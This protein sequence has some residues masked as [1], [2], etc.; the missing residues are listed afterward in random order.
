MVIRILSGCPC[1]KVGVRFFTPSG[2][3]KASTK[4]AHCNQD[5]LCLL[6][7]TMSRPSE[8]VYVI[9]NRVLSPKGEELAITFNGEKKAT[10]LTPKA[11]SNVQKWR[12]KNYDAKTMSVTPINAGNLQAAWGNGFVT[13]LPA[14]NF[15]WTIKSSDTG[16]TIRDGGETV[17]WGTAHAAANQDVT[18]GAGTGNEK[19]RWIFQKSG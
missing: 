11:G 5:T 12:L 8:G 9:V 14:G 3:Y 10:T 2:S 18:I 6:P 15:V 4:L 19:Q 1:Q 16:Y 13:V 7:E 17:F